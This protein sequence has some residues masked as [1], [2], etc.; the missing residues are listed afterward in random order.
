MVH[1][2][3][4]SG[5]VDLLAWTSEWLSLKRHAVETLRAE[6]EIL[7]AEVNRLHRR[8]ARSELG[9]SHSQASVESSI[10]PV[11]VAAGND[12]ASG[13]TWVA[14]Q[15]LPAPL[16]TVL[17]WEQRE[18][19]CDRIGA[20]IRRGLN[21]LHR[22]ASGRDLIP[23]ASRIW[24]VAQN[25]EGVPFDTLQVYRTFTACRPIV[26]RG[27]DC[28]DSIFVG[29]PSEREARRVCAAAGLNWPVN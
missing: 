9:E 13:Y 26:K 29:L 20:W 6:I 25:Y 3:L 19:I 27:A 11:S 8:V 2:G 18:Q 7:R 16:P 23:L 15:T 12:T 21:G 5:C 14:S 1:P 28:G 10:A 22:G 4:F 24:I 17:S